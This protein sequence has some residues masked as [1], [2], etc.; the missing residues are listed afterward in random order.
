MEVAGGRIAAIRRAAP[1]GARTI[2][3]RGA[4]VAPGFVD[5]HVWG[6]PAVVARECV[7]SGTTAFLATL[8]PEGPAQLARDIQAHT[9]DAESLGARCLGLHLEGPFLNPIRGGVLPRRWM[10]APTVRELERLWR[11]SRGR[12]RLLTL[13]PERPGAM[14]AIR[15]CRRHRI[16]V[17]LGH[18]DADAAC[19]GRAVAAGAVAVTHVFNGMRPFHHRA[20]GLLDVALTEPRLTAMVIADG[21]HVSPTALRLL[22]AAKGAGRVALVTDS[23]RL[24]QAAW[25]FVQRAGAYYDRHGTLAGSRLTMI[26]AVRNAVAL[27]GASLTDAVRMASEVPARLLGLRDRGT[28]GLGQ[29][30]D[31]VAFDRQFRVRVTMIGGR[32]VYQRG[33]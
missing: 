2:N 12:V 11:A 7:R 21:I 6:D 25:S 31:L 27:G 23:V 33:L 30:A 10:R 17:S 15:W 5:L 18:S 1:P 8:G 28:I 13:A 3:V 20:P 4:Y 19:A 26:Q 14:A 29:R 24:Q 22:V 32:V 16:V 9:H